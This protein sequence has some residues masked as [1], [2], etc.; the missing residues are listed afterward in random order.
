MLANATFASLQEQRGRMEG[1]GRGK[2]MEG[3]TK[4]AVNRGGEREGERNR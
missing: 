1:R 3:E 4:A 2:E